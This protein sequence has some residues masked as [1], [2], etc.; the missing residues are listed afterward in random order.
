MTIVV[1]N[2]AEGE[3]L[4]C[5]AGRVGRAGC[6]RWM[7][8]RQPSWFVMLPVLGHGIIVIAQSCFIHY[9]A[10][11]S[12]KLANINIMKRTTMNTLNTRRKL[13]TKTTITGSKQ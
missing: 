5:L 8:F 7:D 3:I 13:K 10:L 6:L 1:V 9:Y 12:P 11:S 4:V 2:V